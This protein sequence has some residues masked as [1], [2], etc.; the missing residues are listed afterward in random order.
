M[1]ILIW[2]GYQSPHWNKNTYEKT[3]IGG[4]E[5][6]VLK[7]VEYFQ[8]LGHNVIVSGDVV[9]GG[10][11]GVQYIHHSK[12]LDYRGPVNHTNPTALKVYSHFDVV[13]ASNY[14]HYLKYLEKNYQITFDKS[15]FWMHNLTFY[16]WFKG[17]ELGE[18]KTYFQHPKLTKIVGVS[19]YH[20]SQL[21]ND[22]LVLFEYDPNQSEEIIT[23]VNNAI[24]LRDFTEPLDNKIKGRIIWSSAT[25]RGIDFILENWDDWKKQLPHLSLVIC[26]PP[27]AKDWFKN[28]LSN[29]EDVEWKGALNPTQL[30]EQQSMAE[31]W[32]YASNYNETYCITALEMMI[33]KVKIITTGSGNIKNLIGD[34][35]RGV[36]IGG[37]DSNL[38]IEALKQEYSNDML[39]RAFNYAK[40]QNWN[41]RIQEWIK[42]ITQ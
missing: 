21:N 1:K 17:S 38:V 41:N 9:T 34:G 10:F 16:K 23:H 11:D 7:L 40:E 12:L 5:Y 20:E 4:S 29:L 25:D 14:I 8:M 35:E 3:G 39:D 27:Y 32:I 36:M 33:Q 22:A 30:R 26:T 24:D 2:S 28:D 19:N 6:C 42:L 37:V 31:Y 18:W 15:Y 13:I